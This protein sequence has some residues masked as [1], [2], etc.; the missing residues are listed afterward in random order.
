MVLA[1]LISFLLLL[2][3]CYLA[4]NAGIPYPI[5]S[6]LC[7][8]FGIPPVWIISLSPRLPT[9]RTTPH[10]SKIRYGIWGLIILISIFIPPIFVRFLLRLLVFAVLSLTYPLP[11]MLHIFEHNFY[12]PLSILVTDE[13][14]G[15]H[16]PEG[17]ARGDTAGVMQDDPNSTDSLL[18]RKERSLQR[19]R[20]GRR[21]LWDMI[22]WIILLPFGIVITAWATGSALR[23]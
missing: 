7:L 4:P 12:P 21:I 9:S 18:Q 3:W 10:A 22:V 15:N 11:A 6:A 13:A 5:L 23:Y 17:H 2:P 14:V 20:L 16:D 8:I 19:R 1:A